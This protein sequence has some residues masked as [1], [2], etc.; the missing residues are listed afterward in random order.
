[1][2]KHRWVA[3]SGGRRLREAPLVRD[4]RSYRGTLTL[5]ELC[6]A[7]ALDPNRV[8]D[9]A[10][11]TQV[12][13]DNDIITKD[14]HGPPPR[15][16]IINRAGALRLAKLALQEQIRLAHLERPTATPYRGSDFG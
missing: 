14:G 4:L 9:L 8:T 16:P 2:G 12:C 5:A 1:M 15:L 11:I 10:A 13:R 7:L 3:V 6:L